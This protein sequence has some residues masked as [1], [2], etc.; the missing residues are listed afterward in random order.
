MVNKADIK[1]AECGCAAHFVPSLLLAQRFR[2][3]AWPCIASTAVVSNQ[4]GHAGHVDE[5]M[6]NSPVLK[7]HH[8]RGPHGRVSP[9]VGFGRPIGISDLYVALSASYEGQFF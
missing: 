9:A 3:E 8:T 6:A 2:G 7:T 4:L 5:C 1:C